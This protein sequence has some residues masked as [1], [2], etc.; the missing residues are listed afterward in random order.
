MLRSFRT[1]NVNLLLA[2]RSQFPAL[3]GFA[4]CF[5]VGQLATDK[6][7]IRKHLLLPLPSWRGSCVILRDRAKQ[8]SSRLLD[9]WPADS[10][11]ALEFESS[12]ARANRLIRHS[13]GPTFAHVCV[14]QSLCANSKQ[15]A[16]WKG[17]V[18]G[19]PRRTSK[20]NFDSMHRDSKHRMDGDR[21]LTDL[22]MLC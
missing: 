6:V 10:V 19:W 17:D 15:R 18:Y 12:P 13:K 21:I 14:R 3:R 2:P 8:L 7:L 1:I 22:K 5:Q 16:G 4:S 20:L 11:S 9:G